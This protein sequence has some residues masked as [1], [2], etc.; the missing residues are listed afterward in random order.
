MDKT[1]FAIICRRHN[2]DLI[3]VW[4]RPETLDKAK[5]DLQWCRDHKGSEFVFDLVTL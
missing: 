1:Y 2:S 5:A 4:S 3:T